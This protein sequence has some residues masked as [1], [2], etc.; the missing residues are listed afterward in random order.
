MN[1]SSVVKYLRSNLLLT[2]EQIKNWYHTWLKQGFDA[3][4]AMLRNNPQQQLFCWGDHPTFADICLIP[5]VYNAHRFDFSMKN[6][7]TLLRIYNYCCS[8][9]YFDQAKPE[10]HKT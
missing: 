2:E 6:Y 9:S 8:L 7:P 3:L 1:N 4:E 5:Q 10:N